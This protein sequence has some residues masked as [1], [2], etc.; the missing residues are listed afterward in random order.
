[1]KTAV[2]GSGAWGTALALALLENGN[3]VALWSYSGEESAR[4]RETG[5]TPCCGAWRCR[6]S[7]CSPLNWTA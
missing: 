4:L 1:M 2:I 5:R 6:R 7:W 3:E